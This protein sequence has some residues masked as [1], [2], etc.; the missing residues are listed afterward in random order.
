ML[1][2][3][4]IT[5]NESAHIEACL[6]S[7]AWADEIIVLD[8][9]SE[10]DT[11]SKCL[12]YTDKVYQTDW[13]GFGIQKQRAVDKAKG[14]WILSIDA[15]EIVTDDLKQE[16]QQVLIAPGF[17]GYNIPRLSSY[18]GKP[19]RHGGW[20]PDYTPRLFRSDCGHF[21]DSPV[22]ERIVVTGS[23]GKLTNPL[24]HDAFVDLEE[25]LRKI[26]SYSSL[27]AKIQLDKGKRTSLLMAICRGLWTF[28]RTYILK[29]A[30]LD[31]RY[32][33]MLSISNAEGSY[34]KYAKLIE[35]QNRRE[36]KQCN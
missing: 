12:K 16:I 25:V 18:C 17:Q 28:F 22:H 1:S 2:A 31:G 36:T 4:I 3:V 32:G 23:V 30:F 21:T 6:K 9:G 19:M 35:L 8:S 15:D 27:G 5:K 29:A 20:W 34:Y 24:L 10:D 13:P 14:N 7:V 11:V 26:N 33:L